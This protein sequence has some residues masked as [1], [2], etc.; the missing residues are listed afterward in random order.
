MYDLALL[1]TC[2]QPEGPLEI[3]DLRAIGGIHLQAESI[4]P[5]SKVFVGNWHFI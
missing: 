5:I 1:L 2:L 4:K 3:S